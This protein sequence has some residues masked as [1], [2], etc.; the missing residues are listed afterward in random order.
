M[1]KK[2]SFA[3][4]RDIFL[5]K[6]E[7][8]IV[9]QNHYLNSKKKIPTSGRAGPHFLQVSFPHMEWYNRLLFPRM[10]L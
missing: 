6:I 10:D 7:V 3:K 5:K 2:I 9:Y 1:T 8:V 4:I